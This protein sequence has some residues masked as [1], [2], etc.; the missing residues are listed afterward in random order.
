MP[1]P[2]STSLNWCVGFVTRQLQGLRYYHA[3]WRK[4]LMLS[5][6]LGVVLA[7][8]LVMVPWSLATGDYP[9]AVVSFTALLTLGLVASW[10]MR[11]SERCVNT[12][13]GQRAVGGIS[14][15]LRLAVAAPVAG[16]VNLIA[17]ARAYF[18]K[19]V[20][21]RGIRYHIRSGMDVTRTNYAPYVPDSDIDQHSL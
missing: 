4:V 16:F 12:H 17:V 19:H 14:R 1:N 10:L 11:R 15:P 7:G 2:E 9:S 13:L 18:T 20:T 6:F 21:W 3:A 5:V 8:N